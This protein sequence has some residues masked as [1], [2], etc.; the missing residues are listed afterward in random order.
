MLDSPE[1]DKRL[2][3]DA[4]DRA[5]ALPL[6]KLRC[7][8]TAP[9][10]AGKW[11]YP[12]N[13]NCVRV[14]IELAGSDSV[15]IH[16]NGRW[17]CIEFSAGEAMVYAPLSWTALPDT[18]RTGDAENLGLVMQ[19]DFLRLVHSR[20]HGGSGVLESHS[21]HI[22]GTLRAS[23]AG[24]INLLPTVLQSGDAEGTAGMLLRQ[25]LRMARNDLAAAA[26]SEKHRSRE[27]WMRISAYIAENFATLGPRKET[28]EHFGITSGYLSNLFA[29][30]GHGLTFN[31]TVN[32]LRL[33]NAARQLAD[34]TA[35]C[36]IIARNC[37]FPSP[38]YFGM[39]FREHYRCTPLE[40]RKM[41]RRMREG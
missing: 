24:L 4:L 30:Y 15:L 13:F 1:D 31:Q 2:L 5:A 17:Q 32:K 28:A 37:G 25:A 40:Y 11:V 3:L 26:D 23:T 21:F 22:H 29:R 12:Q 36:G 34:S 39:R 9:L 20:T 7:S 38:S 33:E 8:E 35:D 14:S 19:P 18:P 41:Q 10:P 6:R 27:L 16:C